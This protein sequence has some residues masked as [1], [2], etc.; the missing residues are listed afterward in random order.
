MG[1]DLA[2]WA[3]FAGALLTIG[4]EIWRARRTNASSSTS[5]EESG[6]GSNLADKLAL[7]RGVTAWSVIPIAMLILSGFALNAV[8]GSMRLRAMQ[9]HD[10]LGDQCFGTASDWYEMQ[11]IEL[12]IPVVGVASLLVWCSIAYLT[13][14]LVLSF[15]LRAWP[16]ASSFLTFVAR[17]RPQPVEDEDVRPYGIELRRRRWQRGATMALANPAS[18]PVTFTV[19]TLSPVHRGRSPSISYCESSESSIRSSAD[20]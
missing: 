13:F 16:T 4:V 9:V 14:R 10:C 20:D 3:A 1:A 19:N 8:A 17:P 5:V 6:D 11:N 15:A 12:W 7:T 18:A 2:G